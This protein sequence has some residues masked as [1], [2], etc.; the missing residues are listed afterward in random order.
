MKLHKLG[1]ILLTIVVGLSFTAC[2]TDDYY[3]TK[4]SLD[5]PTTITVPPTN[6]IAQDYRI[7]SDWISVRGGGRYTNIDD[8]RF[9]GGAIQLKMY[10]YIEYADLSIA[11]TNYTLPFDINGQLSIYDESQQAQ[12]FLNVLI[13]Q[14]RRYGYV[15]LMVDGRGNAGARIDLSIITDLDVY[16]RD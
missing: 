5:Y 13:E 3:W 10:G 11:G 2:E 6:V 9:L 7:T 1:L 15:T 12:D 8:F 4:G 16:V 14:I